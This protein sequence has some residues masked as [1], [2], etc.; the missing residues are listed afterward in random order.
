MDNRHEFG[1]E[2]WLGLWPWLL[3]LLIGLCTGTL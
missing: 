3:V 2:I 1:S